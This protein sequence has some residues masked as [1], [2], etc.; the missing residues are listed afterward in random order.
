MHRQQLE[1]LLTGDLLLQGHWRKEDAADRDHFAL[2]P[3]KRGGLLGTGTGRRGT[4]RKSEGS[5]TRR[6][7]RTTFN[8][9]D[10]WGH[11]T[12]TQ[13]KRKRTEKNRFPSLI[14]LMVSV[15]VKHHFYLL[16]NRLKGHSTKHIQYTRLHVHSEIVIIPL[17]S[18]IR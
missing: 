9:L 13:S 8:T 15:D 17:L 16:K 2:R 6:A 14:R 12:P 4:E 7:Q 5:M 18:F 1:L 11:K 10:N 3:Q